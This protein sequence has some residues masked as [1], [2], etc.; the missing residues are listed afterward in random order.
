M[1]KLFY[2]KS[3]FRLLIHTEILIELTLG[4]KGDEGEPS[5]LAVN[6]G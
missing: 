4:A 1:E 6:L 2:F 3:C 5:W